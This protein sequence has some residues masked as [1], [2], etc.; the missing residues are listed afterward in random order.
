MALLIAGGAAGEESTRNLE[1]TLELDKDD[2]R[3]VTSLGKRVQAWK[4]VSQDYCSP[5]TAFMLLPR[6][7]PSTIAVDI[8][9]IRKG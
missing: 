3:R 8:V 7:L 2:R 1:G 9:K 4:A 6:L 5:S